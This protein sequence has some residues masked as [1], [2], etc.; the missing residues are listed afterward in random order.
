MTRY[1]SNNWRFFAVVSLTAGLLGVMRPA[2]AAPEAAEKLPPGASIITA[3]VSPQ[4]IEL[5]RPFDYRQVLVTAVLSTGESVDVTRMAKFTAPANF[6]KVSEGGMVR[7]VADGAGEVKIALAGSTIGIP[8]KVSGMKSQQDVSFVRDIMPIISKTGCNAGTCHGSAK[9]KNGFALSLRGYDPLFDHRALTDDVEARRFNR[10]AP[11][12]SLMLMKPAGAV[13][14]VGGVLFQPGEPYYETIRAWIAGGVKLDLDSPRVVKID[15]LPQSAVLPL[16]GMK[17]QMAVLATYSN[18]QVRDVSAEAFVESSNTEVAKVNKHGLVEAIRR[19]E[20]AMLARYEGAYAAATLIVMGDRSGFAWK[21]VPVNNYIDTLVYEKLKN[22]KVQ[23][24]ELCSDAEFIR[25]V[26]IDVTGLPP[27]AEQV[28]AFLSDTRPTKVKRDALIDKL[29]GSPEY[30]EQWTNK[31][32]DLLQVNRRFLGEQGAGALRNWIRDAVA[33]NMPY[34]H[35][36]YQVLTASGSNL[37]NPPAA[38]YKTLRDPDTAMENTTHLFLAVRF[39]CNKCHDH[40]FERWTQGQ[41]YHMASF[42]AQIGR[43]ADPKFKGK[44]IEGTAVRGALPLV[45]LVSDTKS[46]EVTNPRTGQVAAPEFPYTIPDMPPKNV[47]RR[48]QLARWITSKENPYFAKSYVNRVWSYLL[49]VGL[50]EP[51]DDIR[52]GNPPT[53]PKLLDRM[54]EEFIKS[55]FNVQELMKTI[56]KSRTYQHSVVTN[57]WNRDDETNYSHALA[58]RLPAEVLYDAIHRSTGSVSQLPGLPPGSRAAQLLDSTVEVPGSFLDLFGRP[59]RESA[60]ECERSNSSMLL[61]PVLNLVNGPVIANALKD[62]G[63]RLNQLLGREKD[64]ARVVQELYLSVLC[65]QPTPKELEIGTQALKGNEDDYVKLAAEHKRLETDL[66]VYEKE[67]DVRQVQWEKDMKTRVVTWAVLEPETF[68]SKGGAILKKLPDQSILASGKNPFPESYTLSAFTTLTGITGVRLEVLSDASLPS[69]GPGRANNGN[70]VLSEFKI[71]AAKPGDKSSKPV[72]LHRPQADY[73]QPS[74]DIARA[75]DNNP[76]TGWAVAEQTGRNH[77][78]LFETKERIGF[79]GG[80]TLTFKLDQRFEGKDHNIGRFRLAVTTTSPPLPLQ[81]VPEHIAQILKIDAAKRTPQQKA[82]LTGHF[83]APDGE[84][85]RRQRALA[86]HTLPASA[87]AM[88]AQDLA[89]ALLNTPE[90]LFNH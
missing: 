81:A 31:W 80:T 38:Y 35:F 5:K 1:L 69:R 28:R 52:A 65:R 85:A 18:G 74:F 33:K 83:R 72:A 86:E 73:G 89:W 54:T 25:R 8:V 44:Q 40:P 14:H 42:F 71:G 84:L 43:T 39:N 26:S 36:A 82:T 77:V 19:G 17:Q 90:F 32:A 21:D 56:C 61:G 49:G 66:A 51:V 15:V 22:V 88:G 37:E 67:L 41:Y 7:P 59:P 6:L 11:E 3:K 13:A 45:E 12:K 68:T 60:C 55:G 63:N 34:N 53:N 57:A 78:A 70:F 27:P 20:T 87:R 29:V 47:S 50:I 4:T 9:G 76:G 2:E 24:S 58:R 79:A 16:P 75:I 30:V 10:S 23:P 46:G 64:D 48:E 62:P